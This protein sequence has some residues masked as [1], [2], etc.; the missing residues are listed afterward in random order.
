MEALAKCLDLN[1]REVLSK[2]L[3]NKGRD[4]VHLVTLFVTVEITLYNNVI[5]LGSIN[6]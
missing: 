1:F 3:I 2:C 5:T 4:L 6:G